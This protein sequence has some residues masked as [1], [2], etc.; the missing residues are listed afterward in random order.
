MKVEILK[1]ILLIALFIVTLICGFLPVKLVSYSQRQTT[2]A[3]STRQSNRKRY[4]HV[5]SCL[6]CF[7]AGVFLATCLLDL[8]PDVRQNLS[9]VL[10]L[11]EIHT[12]FPVPEFVM[13]FGLFI[14]LITEQIVLEFKE[15]SLQQANTD[16]K[17]LLHQAKQKQIE[18]DALSFKSDLTISGIEDDV[19]RFREYHTQDSA[20]DIEENFSDSSSEDSHSH[21][22]HQH[23]HQH[24]HH[25]DQNISKGHSQSVL[26]SILLT[27]ALS[28]H[29]IFEGLAIGLARKES[30]ILTIT[31]AII[32]HKCTLSLSLGINLSHSKLHY[33]SIIR[34]LLLFSLAAPI[35]ISIGILIIDLWDSLTSSL[36]QGLLQGIACGTF[37]YITFFEIFPSEFNNTK[38]RR[39]C[40]VLFVLFGFSVVCIIMFLNAEPATPIDPC[41]HPRL[42]P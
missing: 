8:F 21:H 42:H 7:S 40:K 25:H 24:H 30:N 6:S 35:G 19:S 4:K 26:R 23:Q 37:L 20:S 13:V 18:E 12:G 41:S 5:F 11:Y 17:P 39:L 33:G 1:V 27:V 31:S 29:S 38:G 28:L 16:K 14:I 10:I 34:S 15:K 9:D 3:G 36:I 2:H 22:H 32:L